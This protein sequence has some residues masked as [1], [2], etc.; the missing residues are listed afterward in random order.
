VERRKNLP[1]DLEPAVRDGEH[2]FAKKR[3]GKNWVVRVGSRG[4]PDDATGELPH[5]K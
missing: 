1:V 4:E 5:G 3:G 2:L